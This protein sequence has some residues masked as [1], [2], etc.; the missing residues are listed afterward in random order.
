M[1]FLD[2]FIQYHPRKKDAFAAKSFQFRYVAPLMLPLFPQQGEALW[3]LWAEKHGKL[4]KGKGYQA[5]IYRGSTSETE[6]NLEN[7]PD[8]IHRVIEILI[9]VCMIVKCDYGWY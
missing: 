5:D 7:V 9:A 4:I 8:A 1:N 2:M 6:V 3:A